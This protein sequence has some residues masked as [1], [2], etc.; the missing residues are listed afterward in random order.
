MCLIWNLP[1]SLCKQNW[2]TQSDLGGTEHLEPMPGRLSDRPA[3]PVCLLFK[4]STK[5]IRQLVLS[6]F[7]S[8][9]LLF[10]HFLHNADVIVDIV[11]RR[12]MVTSGHLVYFPWCSLSGRKRGFLGLARH[13]C[14]DCVSLCP[15]HLS[16]CNSG[17]YTINRH[18]KR[19]HCHSRSSS[20]RKLTD[21]AVVACSSNSNSNWS[22][23][24][25][26]EP[27]SSICQ[28]RLSTKMKQCDSSECS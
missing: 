17:G 11:W 9:S 12:Y 26:L 18:L 21:R 22:S 4:S 5:L 27:T 1:L 2:S 19:L 13:T 23:L 24:K 10:T 25:I 16:I 7:V 3:F 15:E 20:H 28:R 14:F 8:L 6:Q